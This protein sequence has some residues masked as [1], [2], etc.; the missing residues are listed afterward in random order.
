MKI[1]RCVYSLDWLQV[2]CIGDELTQD[3]TELT[4]PQNDK[5]GNHRT[6]KIKESHEF[7]KGYAYNRLV[8]YRNYPIATIAWHPRNANNNPRGCAIK[9]FNAVLYIAD[10]HFILADV[11]ATLG[12][13]AK[14]IT[15]CDLAC[16]L[17]YFF[18]GLHPETFIRKYM[19]KT[20]DT[21]IREGSNKWAVY[22]QKEIQRNTFNS[23][24]WGSRSS[25]VSVYLYNKSKELREQKFKPWIVEAWK[26][27][28][29]K[30]EDVWRVE[31]SVSSSGRGLKDVFNGIIRSLFVDEIATQEGI[32][33]AFK[34]YAAKYFKFRKVKRNGPIRKKDMEVIPLLPL[35]EEIKVKPTTLYHSSKSAKTELAV[36]KELNAMRSEIEQNEG[37]TRSVL[38]YALDEVI[39]EYK[40][41]S[42]LAK[43]ASLYK[44]NIVESLQEESKNHL[45]KEQLFR[46]FQIS[47][48]IAS[49]GEYLQEVADRIASRVASFHVDEILL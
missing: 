45:T 20:A 26:E 41:R 10:W 40:D 17:N 31:I 12:W 34:M 13:H 1:P 36:L 43:R 48:N 2:Y 49:D 4:S 14:S 28:A 18:N 16:D 7:I 19:C 33:S 30:I 21:Y 39:A 46:R 42:I 47:S 5:F 25:G 38:L 27:K 6:Y 44:T 23:I 15:R 22:G 24:R 29:L 9:L 35:D 8:E 32:E 11:L 37:F 3:Y